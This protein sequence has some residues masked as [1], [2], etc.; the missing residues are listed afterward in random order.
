MSK[1]PSFMYD[2][3]TDA[4]KEAVMDFMISWMLRF[5]QSKYKKSNLQ[6]HNY[7]RKLLGL[8]IDQDLKESDSVSSV[9]DWK[10]HHYIDLIVITTIMHE[11]CE[12]VHAILIEDKTYSRLNNPLD[13]YKKKFEEFVDNYSN[14]KR[15]SVKKHYVVLTMFENKESPQKI[16]NMKQKAE[17]FGF[18]VITCDEMVNAMTE[19][20]CKDCLIP[21]TGNYFF[22]SFWGYSWKV[23][24]NEIP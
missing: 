22:D 20:E 2:S 18:K 23:S 19:Q 11:G 17:P 12:E 8:I 13:K 6:I 10:Q 21:L 16:A 5:A 9:E 14:E 7:G 3:S 24:E 1:I 15:V 4:L